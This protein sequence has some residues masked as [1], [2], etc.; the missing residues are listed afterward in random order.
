MRL[1]PVLGWLAG[2]ACLLVLGAV[3]AGPLM[4][5]V[6]QPDYVVAAQDG[7]IEVRAYG[8]MMAAEVEV[9]GE[10]Q[11]AISEGFRVIAAYIFGANG[12]KA[13]IAMTAPV[14][15]QKQE[16]ATT[17]P[18][19]GEAAGEAWTVRFIMPRGW[20]LVG[21]PTPDDARIKLAPI[22]ARHRVVIRF[23]GGHG[24]RLIADRTSE[25]R[26]Y[27]SRRHLRTTGEPVLAFYNPPW[28]LPWFRRNEIMLD[29]AEPY[30]GAEVE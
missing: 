11:A 30:T 7:P 29:L 19:A 1:N 17:A 9:R 23:A 3:A 16:I 27:V 2:S 18:A 4:S 15:Q 6:E 5:H 25:L 12:R 22:P 10:R 8:P 21:L 13:K 26:A 14:Q 20:T 24:S 28:T